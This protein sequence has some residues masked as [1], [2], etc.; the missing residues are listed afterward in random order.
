MKIRSI[1]FCRGIDVRFFVWRVRYPHSNGSLGRC[2]F[3][4]IGEYDVSSLEGYIAIRG[5]VIH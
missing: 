5:R 1:D 4:P 3:I 2:S